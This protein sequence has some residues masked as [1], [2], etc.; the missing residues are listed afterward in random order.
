M[1]IAVDLMVA[2]RLSVRTSIPEGVTS[3]GASSSSDICVPRP[4][5]NPLHLL[6]HRR[7]GKLSCS[8]RSEVAFSVNGQE[9][10]ESVRLADADLL[11]VGDV[12]LRCRF[13]ADDVGQS[14]AT[15]MVMKPSE[16]VIRHRVRVPMETG[17][18]SW[19]IPLSGLIFGTQE[20]VD[21]RLQDSF[22]SRRHLKLIPSELGIRIED[23]ESRNGVFV[24][25]QRIGAADIQPPFEVRIGDTVVHVGSDEGSMSTPAV[26][27]LVGEAPSIRQLKS[28][29]TRV[30]AADIPTLILGE[31]GTGKEI[32]A[33]QVAAASSRARRPFL[34]LNCGALS[35]E[36]LES[37]LF[38]HEKGAFTGAEMR[39]VGAFEAAHQGTLFLDEIGELPLTMQ[40]ALLRAI[41]YGEVRRV[42]SSE[43]F[44]VDVRII[45]ATNRD[46]ESEVAQGTFR[47]DLLHRLNVIVLRATPLRERTGD[48]R[49]LAQHFAREFSPPGRRAVLDEST[50][51]MLEGHRWP[52]NVRELRNVIQRALILSPATHLLP[53]HLHLSV[54]ET[55][56][57]E[58]AEP[59][60]QPADALT[61]EER[62][63]EAIVDALRETRGN[64]SEAAEKLGISRSTIHRKLDRHGISAREWQ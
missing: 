43:A 2:G 51:R 61:M 60:E 13:I 36:L 8:N 33:R 41:E 48:V 5:I 53:E 56:G 17:D 46:L 55:E 63:R 25:A 11:K 45:A 24:G 12:E 57:R 50:L 29:I 18:R 31:T 39:R 59:P 32:I 37:E 23:L 6:F 15:M 47:E 34:T 7:A 4:G 35:P 38:G 28:L 30:A 44:K 1:K 64:K 42:G 9:V 26:P 62:E 10:H 27:A 21:I 40:A 52:G 58:R 20:D 3:F 16:E 14:T 54:V 19:E 22:V 49:I